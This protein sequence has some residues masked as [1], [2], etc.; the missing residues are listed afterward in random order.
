MLT[1]N[2]Y[3][4]ALGREIKDW[5]KR[6][7]PEKVTL[8]GDY[9][10][11]LP[12]SSD[13]AE[14]LFP[15]W[16][17]IDDDRD[18][19]YLSD[20]KPATKEQCYQYFRKLSADK[21]KLYFAVK[22]IHDGH[23]KG[24][25]CVTHIDPNNGVFALAEINWTPLM[26][27]TRLSTESLFL[28]IS[29]FMDKLHYR[30]CEWQTNS[31]NTQSIDSAQRIGFIR[32][33]ILRDKRISKGYAED[34]AFFSITASDWVDTAAALKAWLRKENFDERGRQIHKLE[35]FRVAVNSGEA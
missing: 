10:I 34:I 26:K 14:D 6:A 33:G 4:Q 25:L 2:H 30:R 11:V 3:G 19:T 7:A 21:D 17:S 23:I 15:E 28:I 1:H 5:V 12:L 18:W 35:S 32:E 13:H 9:C 29:Y 27:R 31:L 16:H 8:K 24:M 20:A 22:D